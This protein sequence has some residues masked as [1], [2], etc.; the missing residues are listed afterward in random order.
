[1]NLSF[2]LQALVKG[3]GPMGIV[4]AIVG[5]LYKYFQLQGCIA[6]LPL[7]QTIGRSAESLQNICQMDPVGSGLAVAAVLGALGTIYTFVKHY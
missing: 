4:G 1:M 6:D 3:G 7:A 5:Y 2:F